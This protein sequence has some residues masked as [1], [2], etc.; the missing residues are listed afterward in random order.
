[1]V[2]FQTNP[3]IEAWTTQEGIVR[4]WDGRERYYFELDQGSFAVLSAFGSPVTL[5]IGARLAAEH[6]MIPPEKAMEISLALR[7]AGLLLPEE[8]RTIQ[9]FADLAHSAEASN[10]LRFHLSTYNAEYI[11]YREPAAEAKDI[12]R[13]E[14]L[15]Y[16]HPRPSNYKDYLGAVTVPIRSIR[17]ATLQ[18]DIPLPQLA[19][20]VFGAQARMYWRGQGEFLLKTTPSNGARHPAEAYFLVADGPDSRGGCYHYS[21]RSGEL[22]LLHSLTA[23]ENDILST[24]HTKFVV[25]VSCL[26]ARTQWR[27]RDSGRSFRTLLADL[28]HLLETL[29][30]VSS[31]LGLASAEVAVTELRRLESSI[32]LDGVEE[33]LVA[34]FS[35]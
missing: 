22:E 5:E 34:A 12:E 24:L 8:D 3:L 4:L 6:L 25:C 26:P 2:Q 31:G 15:S 21:V 18:G 16:L 1:M 28:G 17:V 27:Y 9:L 10:V 35:F 32:G 7:N 29:A 14:T 23:E 13:M 30:F 19:D 11:D 20:L 33:W